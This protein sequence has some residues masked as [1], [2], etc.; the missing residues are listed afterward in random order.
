[1][2]DEIEKIRKKKL[3]ALRAKASKV[4]KDVDELKAMQK[5]FTWADFGYD[6]PEWAFRESEEMP[7]A[8]DVCQ[9]RQTV[10]LTGDAKWAMLVTDLL[11]RARLEELTLTKEVKESAD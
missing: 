7:G 4:E 9:N 1:M 2:S 5:E 10:A 6:E 3:E 11:N 8:F